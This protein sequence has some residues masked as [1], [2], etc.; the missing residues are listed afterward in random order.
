MTESEWLKLLKSNLS[1][2]KLNVFSGQ[3]ANNKLPAPSCKDKFQF[4]DLRI[5]TPKRTIVVEIDGAGGITN[6]LKYW[7]YLAGHTQTRPKKKFT[8]IHI[9]DPPY[10]SHIALWKYFYKLSPKFIVK[11]DFILFENGKQQKKNIIQMISD[12]LN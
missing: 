12:L 8:L 1:L 7:P 2:D 3:G 11:A 5:E 6:F 9:F 10:P 4:G